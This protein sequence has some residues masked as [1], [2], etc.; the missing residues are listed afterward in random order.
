V[1]S[2]LFIL[3]AWLAAG[4]VSPALDDDDP[5]VGY[6][7]VENGTVIVIVGRD[8]RAWLNGKAIKTPDNERPEVV[9]RPG[10]TFIH[11]AGRAFWARKPISARTFAVDRLMRVSGRD[12]WFFRKTYS[13]RTEPYGREG[14]R[15]YP[16]K[17]ISTET[18]QVSD[19]REIID[20]GP[21]EWPGIA[22]DP[23]RISSRS[24]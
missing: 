20:G 13:V 10:D 15:V 21:G 23:N 2:T 17:L 9:I 12:A 19:N 18:V 5:F 24:Q 22:V 8:D 4:L 1:R 14:V 7:H 11:A 6:V 3:A 16:D